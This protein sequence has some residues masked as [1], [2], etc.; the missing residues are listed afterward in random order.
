MLRL[1]RRSS[2][3][4]A[5]LVAGLFTAAPAMAADPS[6]SPSTS[7][8]TAPTGYACLDQK[9]GYEVSGPCQ[10]TVRVEAICKGDAAYLSYQLTPEGTPDTTATLVWGDPNGTHVTMS[11]LPLSGT[12]LWPG[13]VLDASGTVTDWPGWTQL[14]DGSWQQGD[15]WSWVRP[16]VPLTF[17]VNP[18]ASVT[19][20]YPGVGTGCNPPTTAVLADGGSAVLASTGSNDLA[21]LA[22][23]AG[24][25]V[26]LG[27]LV[28]G[29]R[30]ALR[31]RSA[32]R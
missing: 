10:L 22:L 30:A 4:I 19:A 20:T 13:T 15:Q 21:P 31:R 9:A 5:L 3:I 14:P 26:V 29:T 12:V 27:A 16:T 6:A 32:T 8:P 25:L 17:Q 11:D 24:G 18:T 28:L 1:A 7:A 23:A 2:A